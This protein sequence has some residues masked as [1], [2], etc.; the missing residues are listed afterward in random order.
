M[1][2]TASEKEGN[3]DQYECHNR[4]EQIIVTLLLTIPG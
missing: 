3:I 2:A 4:S 1:K